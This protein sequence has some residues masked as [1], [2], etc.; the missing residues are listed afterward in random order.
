MNKIALVILLLLQFFSSRQRIRRLLRLMTSIIRNAIKKE[1]K[2]IASNYSNCRLSV[3]EIQ[4]KREVQDSLSLSLSLSLSWLLP[5][6]DSFLGRPRP[7]I[8][9]RPLTSNNCTTPAFPP[10]LLVVAFEIPVGILRRK[11]IHLRA[12][13]T[14][15][16][17]QFWYRYAVGKHI[18][19]AAKASLFT[20]GIILEILLTRYQRHR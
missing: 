5:V 14:R 3:G 7:N 18:R 6:D 12:C 8:S 13:A 19:N 20:H 16:N 15:S 17:R 9:R 4:L 2:E 11:I 1:K 10:A